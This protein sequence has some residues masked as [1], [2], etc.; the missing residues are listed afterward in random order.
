MICFKKR[1]KGQVV[2]RILCSLYE[3]RC[4]VSKVKKKLVIISSERVCVW[5]SLKTEGI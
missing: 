5:C 4:D 3:N 2:Q 1:G